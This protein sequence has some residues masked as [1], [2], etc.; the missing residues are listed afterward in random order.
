MDNPFRPPAAE[1][2]LPEAPTARA[3][4]R[5]GIWSLALNTLCAC[6]PLAIPLGILAIARYR[7]ARRAALEAP[8]RYAPPSEAGL[9]LGILG[10]S[11]TFLALL[12]WAGLM[13][14]WLHG[15]RPPVRP[16]SSG[17]GARLWAPAG[18]P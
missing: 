2:A 6:F 4:L 14:P 8:G 11:M 9:V 3:A 13:I 17:P 7:Q 5:L 16:P 15:G 10:L 12:V 18:R 1:T